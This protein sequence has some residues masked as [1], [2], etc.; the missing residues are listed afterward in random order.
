[1]NTKNHLLILF[2]FSCSLTLAQDPQFSQAYSG[3]LDLN[4]AFAGAF[5]HPNISVGYRNQWPGLTGNYVSTI[6]S[7]NQF[8]NKI[9][10]GIGAYYLKDIQG[11]GGLVTHYWNFDFSP[12]FIIGNDFVL[13]PAIGATFV[14]KKIDWNKFV[15]G[16]MIDSRYTYAY[17]DLTVNKKLTNTS[18][19]DF[20][21]GVLVYHRYFDIGF[22]LDHL[23]KPY[24]KFTE[25]SSGYNLP[26][27]FTA[28]G[29]VY[30]PLNA[31]K[32]ILLSPNLIYIKQGDIDSK[33]LNLCLKY[34]KGLA[35]IGFRGSDSMIFSIGFETNAI[36]LSY[37]YDETVSRLAGAKASSHEI[38]L[39]FSF[40]NEKSKSKMPSLKRIAF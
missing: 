31:D 28:H 17:P 23:F 24:V 22:A 40:L 9:S 36:R 20:S 7:Y 15:I 6:V 37:C 26:R 32:D 8:V 13:K 18:T 33:L 12:S 35:G 5:E 29:S 1:M 27:R 19:L 14:Y 16:D 2:I 4:P 10:S 21:S 39:S 3:S 11:E 38:F 30:I 25:P 34:K